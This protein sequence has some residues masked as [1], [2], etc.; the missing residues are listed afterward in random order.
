MVRD[1]RLGRRVRDVASRTRRRANDVSIVRHGNRARRRTE[2]ARGR[3]GR[4]LHRQRSLG[5]RERLHAR[6]LGLRELPRC[7]RRRDARR[8]GRGPTDAGRGCAGHRDRR[9]RYV[10]DHRAR[11]EWKS[12][13]RGR[14]RLHPRRTHLLAVRQPARGRCT[15]VPAPL[16]LLRQHRHRS[17]RHRP[18]RDRRL[19]TGRANQGVDAVVSTV[20]R[21]T[22]GAGARGARRDARRQRAVR[23]ST[24]SSEPTGTHSKRTRR[25]KH[26][27]SASAS[28][29]RT[30]SARRR[31]Q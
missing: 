7:A 19:D 20:A 4:R 22:D 8:I 30:R 11:R 16:G 15:P 23:T 26:P 14:G 6:R 17:P 13:R 18:R 3:S 5:V 9:R 21:R 27:G 1:D 31:K 25:S 10:A 24:T 28:R 2:R 29:R 12:R